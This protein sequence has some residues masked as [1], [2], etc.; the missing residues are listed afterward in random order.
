[1]ARLQIF[2]GTVEEFIDRK[3]EFAGM[4]L[5]V[6]ALSAEE[7]AAENT[8]DEATGDEAKDWSELL[9]DPPDTIRDRAHLEALLLEGIN[10]PKGS[11]TDQEW[12]DIREEVH[13]RYAA[14]L[15]TKQA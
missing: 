15:I 1:M 13:R 3:E 9:P 6:F 12:V 7:K 2:E 5:Q 8:G 11:I 14:R 4:Q 10:S